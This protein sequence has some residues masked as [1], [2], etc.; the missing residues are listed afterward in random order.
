MGETRNIT[1]QAN[2]D[3]LIRLL[4]DG[5]YS[6]SDIF[7]RELIQNGHDSIIRRMEHNESAFH[8]EIDVTYDVIEKSITFTDNG[9]GM[10]ER[11]IIEFLSTI[12]STGTGKS[13]GELEAA[14]SENLIGQFGIGMLSSFLVANKVR[15]HTRKLGCEHAYEWINMGS[16]QCLL[17]IIERQKIGTSVTVFL[18]PDFTY[19]LDRKKLAEIITRYCDFI[20]VPISVQGKGPVPPGTEHICRGS[21]RWTPTAPS[22]ITASPTTPWT[23]FLLISMF[24]IT[25]SITG[26]RAFFT[27]PICTFP[28]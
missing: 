8:G 25:V 21:R 22:S 12:G 17:T 14:L 5:L 6:T 2:F 24:R 16:T 13:R 28:V 18:R 23:Y 27:S 15:V 1:M 4:A 3:G 20:T 7:I 11:D 26:L 10:D 19:L 9:I